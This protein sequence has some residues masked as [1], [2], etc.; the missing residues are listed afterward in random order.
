MTPEFTCATCGKEIQAGEFIA[1]IGA[2]PPS[3]LSTPVG[4]AD[5]IFDDIGEIYCKECLPER[6]DAI[7][8]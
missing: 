8:S 3:G 1:I 2:A 4:R 6:I 7:Y 5:K